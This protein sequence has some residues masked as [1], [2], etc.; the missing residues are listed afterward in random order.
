MVAPSSFKE[1]LAQQRA[2]AAPAP[3]ARASCQPQAHLDAPELERAASPT[4]AASRQPP[5]SFKEFLELRATGPAE[6]EADTE[7]EDEAPAEEEEAPAVVLARH[8]WKKRRRRAPSRSFWR[9]VYDVVGECAVPDGC[10]VVVG[11]ATPQAA[12]EACSTT[13]SAPSSSAP[14]PA[15]PQ[16]TGLASLPV[17]LVASIVLSAAPRATEA[18]DACVRA[19]A[20]TCKWLRRAAGDDGVWRRVVARD[21]GGP[22]GAAVLGALLS[23]PPLLDDS[24]EVPAKLRLSAPP[25][26]PPSLAAAP[27]AALPSTVSSTSWSYPGGVLFVERAA[28]EGPSPPTF[29]VH[30]EDGLKVVLGAPVRAG[31]PIGELVGELSER[32]RFVP[33]AGDNPAADEHARRGGILGGG[34]AALLRDPTLRRF[35]GD[36]AE[37]YI[38]CFDQSRAGTPEART[39]WRLSARDTGNALLRCVRHTGAP[40]APASA[41]A[42]PEIRM[43]ADGPRVRLVATRDLEPLR[44]E[45]TWNNLHVM[46]GPV[47]QAAAAAEPASVREEKT[48]PATNDLGK[49]LS[50]IHGLNEKVVKREGTHILYA[51]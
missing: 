28:R 29:L 3:A 7:E 16:A 13:T 15:A 5:L 9:W 47:T 46:S 18:E 51:F 22:L 19:L 38:D 50:V 10:G 35:F 39:Q 27:V 36:E 41:S 14:P 44:D 43:A 2:S 11:V 26:S 48:R 32:E 23:L 6:P 1:W 37:V 40:G 21:H 45:V 24:G 8:T 34:V 33:D 12:L 4:E 30:T 25:L 31:D 42:A 49:L 20:S 17:H